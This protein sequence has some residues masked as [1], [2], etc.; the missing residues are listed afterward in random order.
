VFFDMFQTPSRE[1]LDA[2][3]ARR[4]RRS[5]PS[6]SGAISTRAGRLRT[7]AHSLP[8]RQADGTVRW[9]GHHRRQ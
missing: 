4:S 7:R 6:T 9:H 1:E 8:T 2:A 3:I 5:R